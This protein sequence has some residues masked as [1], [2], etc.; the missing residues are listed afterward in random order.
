MYCKYSTQ[1]CL[2]WYTI[3]IATQDVAARGLDLP[4]VD[5]ILQVSYT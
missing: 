5:W 2:V 1:V 3:D 4:Q